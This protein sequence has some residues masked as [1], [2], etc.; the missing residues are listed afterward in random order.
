MDI[1]IGQEYIINGYKFMCVKQLD[2][3]VYTFTATEQFGEELWKNITGQRN[4][5]YI[6]KPIHHEKVEAWYQN[7]KNIEADN[8]AW[9]PYLVSKKEAETDF[10]EALKLTAVPGDKI[11]YIKDTWTGSYVDYDENHDC[12]YGVE[13]SGKVN[14]DNIIVAHKGVVAPSINIDITK[15]ELD[16]NKIIPIE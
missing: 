14:D 2:K 16:G 10:N 11:V 13:R 4:A 3:T 9:G 7:I 12:A 1:K 15:C 8:Y 5:D 6:H